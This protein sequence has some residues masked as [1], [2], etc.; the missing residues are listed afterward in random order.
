MLESVYLFTLKLFVQL[1]LNGYGAMFGILVP[2]MVISIIVTF[3]SKSKL[4]KFIFA[5]LSIMTIAMVLSVM[6]HIKGI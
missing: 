5:I 2:L 4:T 6:F 1:G 3:L